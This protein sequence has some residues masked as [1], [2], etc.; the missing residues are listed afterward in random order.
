MLLLYLMSSPNSMTYFTHTVFHSSVACIFDRPRYWLTHWIGDCECMS[1]YYAGCIC[2]GDT[3]AN[4]DFFHAVID[5]AV[6]VCFFVCLFFKSVFFLP[7]QFILLS[8]CSSN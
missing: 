6:C 8:I 1:I 4:V 2:V 7:M 5:Y 3:V